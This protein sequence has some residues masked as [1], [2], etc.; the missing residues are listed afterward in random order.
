MKKQY[1]KP[2]IEE[3]LL[4]NAISL[5]LASLPDP[6]ENEQNGMNTRAKGDIDPYHYDNW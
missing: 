2:I 1:I 5:Q 3:V 4:D 6:S